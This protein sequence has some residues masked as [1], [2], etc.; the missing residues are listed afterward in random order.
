M[1]SIFDPPAGGRTFNAADWLTAIDVELNA[2]RPASEQVVDASPRPARRRRSWPWAVL[3]YLVICSG[4]TAFL[5]AVGATT[6][7]LMALGVMTLELVI[8][9]ILAWRFDRL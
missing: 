6:L 8:W 2:D 1:T 4:I 5:V 3:A 9:L 7:A